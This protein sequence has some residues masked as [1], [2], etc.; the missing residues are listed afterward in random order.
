[1][2]L[3][4]R[5]LVAASLG[6][7]LG[8][9]CQNRGIDIAQAAQAN[10][11]DIKSFQDTNSYVS[12]A[13]FAALL[14][15]LAGITDDEI[16][17]L[18][19]G[20]AYQLGNTGPFGFGLMNA[21]SFGHA[22]KFFSR[23]GVLIADQAYFHM[24]VGRKTGS[25]QWSY[26]PLIV[27]K[28]Q[29]ADFATVIGLRQFRLFLGNAWSPLLVHLQRIEPQS[30]TEHRR[31]MS[32]QMAFGAKTNAIYFSSETLTLQNPRA[33][34]R[35]FEMMEQ[36]CEERLKRKQS[37][38]AL[39]FRVRDEILQRLSSRDLSLQDIARKLG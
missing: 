32:P 10:A 23:Y 29:F 11:L 26:S 25:M 9:Y 34:I 30:A 14:E 28:D 21:P 6:R 20:L 17:G 4:D 2:G 18:K 37:E 16:F 27:A 33:D 38:I 8:I 15:Q 1:M 19:Y 13:R 7:S 39:E 12:L 31:H 5:Y 22:L 35:L 3:A 24:E 36:Q